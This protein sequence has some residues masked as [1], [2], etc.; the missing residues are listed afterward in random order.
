MLFTT[1]KRTIYEQSKNFNKLKDNLNKYQIEFMELKNTI[2]EVKNLLKESP[3]TRSSKKEK[4]WSTGNNLVRRL[5][6]REWEIVWDIVTSGSP[7]WRRERT[8]EVIW[9]ASFLLWRNN[10][11]KLPKFRETTHISKKPNRSQIKKPNR[12]QTCN[13]RNTQWGTF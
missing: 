3:E 8:R 7:R 13:Q 2:T 11:W 1:I 4:R 10:G 6:K 12:F 9:I 5:K